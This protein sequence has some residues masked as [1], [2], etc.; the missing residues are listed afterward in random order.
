MPGTFFHREGSSYSRGLRPKLHAL[1]ANE[2]DIIY[3]TKQKDC[4]RKCYRAE[5]AE[6]V[7][8]LN[9]LGWTPWT[10]RFYQAVMTR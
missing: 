6:S 5:M 3:N 7:Y 2:T 4:D 8:C 10:L 1:F 9:P